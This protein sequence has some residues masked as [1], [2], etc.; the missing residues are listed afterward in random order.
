M[1]GEL[2]PPAPCDLA[3]ELPDG[4]DRAR[5]IPGQGM[6]ERR[7]RSDVGTNSSPTAALASA[8]NRCPS[9]ESSRWPV[10]SPMSR[11]RLSI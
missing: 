2:S 11:A 1:H 6:Q 8:M 5:P 10:S 7:Q 3:R 4:T 9:S